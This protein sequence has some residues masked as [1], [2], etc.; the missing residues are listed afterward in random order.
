MRTTIGETRAVRA[1]L[2]LAVSA[3]LCWLLAALAR[4]DAAAPALDGLRSVSEQVQGLLQ[5]GDTG[6]GTQALQQGIV[7]G[8]DALIAAYAEQGGVP[9]P[10]P[11]QK[12]GAKVLQEAA[13][14]GAPVKPARES[15]LPLG[16]WSFGRTRPPE[17][18]AEAWQP[19]LPEAERK[20]ISDAFR[21]GRLPGRYE[22]LLRQYNR[23]LAEEGSGTE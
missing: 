17:A 5:Q 6:A 18:F 10:M 12:A 2:L 14:A 9:V 3:V 7:N 1:Q 23:R 20:R 8:L 4:G 13:T 11:A 22:D 16:E 15:V 19:R 21:T